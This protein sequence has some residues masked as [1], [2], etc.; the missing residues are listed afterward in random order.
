MTEPCP[1]TMSELVPILFGHAAFQ[2]LNAASELGLLDLLHRRPGLTTDEVARAL[3]LQVRCASVLLLGTTA[4]R[5]TVKTGDCFANAPAIERT[6]ADGTW[7]DLRNIVEFQA[8]ISYA[9]AADYADSLRKGENVGL[10]HFPG[11]TGDLYGRLSNTPGLEELFYR[12]MD[13]WSRISNPV[14]LEGVDYSRTCRILDIGGGGALNAIALATAHPH[15]RIT[16]LDRPSALELAENNIARHGLTDRIDTLAA[17]IFDDEYPPGYDCHLFAHQLVIWSPEQNKKL[18]RKAIRTVTDNGRVLIFNAF[19][20]DDGA[21]PLY[22]ALDGVYFATLPFESSTIY[23]WHDYESW[24]DECGYAG[25]R[26]RTIDTWT[27]HGVVEAYKS[28]STD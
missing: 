7:R 27:P 22:T 26:R 13:S 21:G 1:L 14:L 2:Q 4:L 17:D 15:L 24:L 25:Y 19:T 5:L 11:N 28:A 23:T 12:G 16:V 8:R 18:L 9:P 3:G 20:N 6:F 10:R